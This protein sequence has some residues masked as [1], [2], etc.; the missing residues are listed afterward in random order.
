MSKVYICSPVHGMNLLPAQEYSD[1]TPIF[2]Y[3]GPPL[4]FN[5]EQIIRTIHENVKGA[6]PGD[7]LV[8]CG[9]PSIMALCAIEVYEETN[10]KFKILKWDKKTNK[11][12]PINIKYP[13]YEYEY[14]EDE[15]K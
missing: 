14:G 1:E 8:L 6:S 10:G 12:Y 4:S 3:D 15:Y 13:D 9:D 5:S 11:Y 2:L 7:F